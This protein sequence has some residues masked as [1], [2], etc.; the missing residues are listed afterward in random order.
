MEA[1][2]VCVLYSIERQREIQNY[3]YGINIK[4]KHYT[5]FTSRTE[6]LHFQCEVL[7]SLNFYVLQA[8]VLYLL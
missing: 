2:Q 4:K 1:C 6:T 5:V 8:M 7:K 3:G